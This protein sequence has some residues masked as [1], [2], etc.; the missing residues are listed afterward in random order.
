MPVTSAAGAP[1]RRSPHVASKVPHVAKQQAVAASLPAD[2]LNPFG[3]PDADDVTQQTAKQA[4]GGGS[5]PFST[6]PFGDDFD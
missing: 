3:D 1:A 2:S 6:N 5:N 4:S